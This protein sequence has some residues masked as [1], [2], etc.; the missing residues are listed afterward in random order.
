M[1]RLKMQNVVAPGATVFVLR[2]SLEKLCFSRLA[3]NKNARLPAGTFCA[4][5][6]PGGSRTRNLQLRRLTLYP[7]ELQNRVNRKG[8]QIYHE[9]S[10]Q[11]LLALLFQASAYL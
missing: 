7:V 10:I 11:S 4:L 5:S 3:Q 9:I 6:D 8:V 2:N 1:S